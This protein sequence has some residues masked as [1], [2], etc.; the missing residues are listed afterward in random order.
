MERAAGN[1]LIQY[2]PGYRGKP[3]SLALPVRQPAYEFTAFPPVF[4]GLLP[5]GPSLESLVQRHGLDEND[6]FAQLMVIGQ[7]MV[8]SLVVSEIR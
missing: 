2:V 1:Y 3:I 8:G 5:E 7:D 6:L 4:E